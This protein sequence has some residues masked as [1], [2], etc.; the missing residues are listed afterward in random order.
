M[1]RGETYLILRILGRGT[2]S[3]LQNQ[4]IRPR[5]RDFCIFR[6]RIS[7]KNESFF[8][9]FEALSIFDNRFF[10]LIQG[11]NSIKLYTGRCKLTWGIDQDLVRPLKLLRSKVMGKKRFSIWLSYEFFIFLEKKLI[12]LGEGRN[13]SYPTYFGTRNILEFTESRNSPAFSRFLHF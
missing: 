12:G 11:Q 6:F 13:I 3:N 4:E 1:E 2:S 7:E 5:L 8:A 9:F 10:W